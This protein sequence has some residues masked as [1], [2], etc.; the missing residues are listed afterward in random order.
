[1]EF[2]LSGMEHEADERPRRVSH[3]RI[4]SPKPD[5]TTSHRALPASWRTFFRSIPTQLPNESS[6]ANQPKIPDLKSDG[7]LEHYV[8]FASAT[9]DSGR[10][11]LMPPRP[12]FSAATSSPNQPPIIAIPHRC[13]VSRRSSGRS[14]P[15]QPPATAPIP[16]AA[17]LP[18]TSSGH[19]AVSSLVCFPKTVLLVFHAD[20]TV[21]FASACTARPPSELKARP[22][23]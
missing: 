5:W 8:R 20:V 19:A 11:C 12:D 2:A 15:S 9:A 17:Q 4:P 14:A 16:I 18:R 10:L 23:A 3:G 1:M 22:R 7:L 6:R 21:R 13:D